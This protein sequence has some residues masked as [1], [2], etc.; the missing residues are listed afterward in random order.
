VLIVTEFGRAVAPNGSGGTDH[1]T[2]GAAFVAGGA[3]RGGR[4]ISDWPGLGQR[5]LYEER[6]LRPTLDLRALFKAALAAQLGLGEAALETEVFP[7]SR[8]VRPLDGVFV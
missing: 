3:V 1:G 8:A 7:D 6:D 2:A 4:V 5:D